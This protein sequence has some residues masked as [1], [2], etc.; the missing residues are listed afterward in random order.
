MISINRAKGHSHLFTSAWHTN[1]GIKT[2]FRITEDAA[3]LCNFYSKLKYICVLHS[4][5]TGKGAASTKLASCDRT[6][7]LTSSKLSR[8]VSSF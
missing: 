3:S 2:S 7:V 1:C 4:R 8:V 6:V 5:I